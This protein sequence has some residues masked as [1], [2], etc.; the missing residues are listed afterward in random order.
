[1][2]KNPIYLGHLMLRRSG[3]LMDLHYQRFFPLALYIDAA[4]GFIHPSQ[5][6]KILRIYLQFFWGGWGMVG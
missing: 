3:C 2:Y 1:M 4:L 5:Q 6:I